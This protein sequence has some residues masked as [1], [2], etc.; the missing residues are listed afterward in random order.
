[1]RKLSQGELI[2]LFAGVLLIADLL[3]L[4]WYEIDMGGAAARVG[5][6]TTLSGVQS[7]NGFYGVVA[8]ILTLVM[9]LQIVLDKLTSV[10]LPSLRVLW[11]LVH[12]IAGI[13]VAVMLVIKL[14]T[15]AAYVFPGGGAYLGAALGV[16]V[17]FGGCY[18]I[19]Q[20]YAR[21]TA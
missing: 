9:V 2:V 11:S 1:M 8:L 13:T 17:G 3:F 7:P 12:M 21:P 20:T 16:A 14:F 5:I 10:D 18:T 6:D 19:G 15:S 4:P